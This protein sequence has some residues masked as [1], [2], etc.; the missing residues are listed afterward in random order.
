MS[1]HK[2]SFYRYDAKKINYKILSDF[3][4]LREM[5][6]YRFLYF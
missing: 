6:S 1:F 4:A 3:A 5:M 2:K